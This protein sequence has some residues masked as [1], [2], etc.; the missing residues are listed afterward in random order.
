MFTASGDALSQSTISSLLQPTGGR[1]ASV[2]PPSI[3]VL[4]NVEIVY[5]AFSQAAQRE[6]YLEWRN[7]W[8]GTYLPTALAEPVG[9]TKVDGGLKA[10]QG[11]SQDV[12][13]GKVRGKLVID[14]QE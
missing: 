14:I 9:Y 4:S 10:L 7:W 11:A 6:E 5:T 12:F 1:F 8:Y 13:D 2:L 3:E